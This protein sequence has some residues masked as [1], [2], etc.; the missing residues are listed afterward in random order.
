MTKKVNLSMLIRMKREGV[1][2]KKGLSDIEKLVERQYL[3]DN[4]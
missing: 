3:K 2:M 1:N 4:K